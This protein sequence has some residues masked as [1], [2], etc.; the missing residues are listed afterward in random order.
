MKPNRALAMGAIFSIFFTGSEVNS[1]TDPLI[2]QTNTGKITEQ[3]PWDA[4]A[5]YWEISLSVRNGETH[6]LCRAWEAED[7]RIPRN[8]PPST[9]KAGYKI[10]AASDRQVRWQYWVEPSGMLWG[11]TNYLHVTFFATWIRRNAT[12]DELE[13]FGCQTPTVETPRPPLCSGMSCDDSTPAPTPAPL[14]NDEYQ[15]YRRVFC[16]SVSS[17]RDTGGFVDVL[18]SSNRSCADARN[19]AE[20]TANS[21]DVCRQPNLSGPIYVDEEESRTTSRQWVTTLSCR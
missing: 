10:I 21:R 17:N 18:G 5:R 15:I 7:L 20:Q 19:R 12:Q 14:P 1:Q 6:R 2:Y 13:R 3:R 16:R 11:S 8:E 4:S 9:D